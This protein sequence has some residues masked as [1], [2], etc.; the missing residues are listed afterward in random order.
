MNW[1]QQKWTEYHLVFVLYVL[2]HSIVFTLPTGLQDCT[3][4]SK[5]LFIKLSAKSSGSVALNPC[6]VLSSQSPTPTWS[7]ACLCLC[8]ITCAIVNHPVVLIKRVSYE[9][10]LFAGEC[11]WTWPVIKP[12]KSTLMMKLSWLMCS[13][14]RIRR[15]ELGEIDLCQ[16][17]IIIVQASLIRKLIAVIIPFTNILLSMNV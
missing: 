12:Q 1:K 14:I 15:G 2:A 16:I 11:H 13:H 5:T 17:N 9:V 4:T 3:F 6:Q 7:L 10:P 8:F